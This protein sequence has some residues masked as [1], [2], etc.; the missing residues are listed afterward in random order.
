MD[1]S[2]PTVAE[3]IRQTKPFSS[4]RQEGALALVLASEALRARFASL[5]AE[6]GDLTPQ[7]YNVL[8]ILAGAGAKGLPTLSIVERMIENTPG[9]TRLVDRLEKKGF[10]TRGRS[11]E[12]GRQVVCRIAPKGA[13]KLKT[14]DPVVNVI[15][16]DALSALTDSE[17]E[18][19]IRLANKVRT[20]QP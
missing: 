14:L 2:A 8:R 4:R 17:V 6:N 18:T 16:Q 10:V 7:Q 19:L 3:A 9:I 13:A 5:L 12:D 15:D 20:S 1:R 11:S